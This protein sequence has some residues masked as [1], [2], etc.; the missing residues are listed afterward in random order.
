[1]R[2]MAP[3]TTPGNSS[4]SWGKPYFQAWGGLPSAPPP[5]PPTGGRRRRQFVEMV[6][7]DVG[8]KVARRDVGV[9]ET[10]QDQGNGGGAGGAGVGGRVARPSPRGPAGRRPP[11]AAIR[12]PGSGLPAATASAPTMASKRAARPRAS[13]RAT[14]RSVRLLV[15][16]A[17]RARR[18]QGVQR[19]RHAG[20]GAAVIGDVGP[21]V[22][23]EALEEFVQARLGKRLA[24]G[25]E[26]SRD[27]RPAP[28]ADHRPRRLHGQ[29]GYAFGAKHHVQSVHQVRRGV[30]QG[31]VEVQGD[32]G[33]GEVCEVG[34]Q[35]GLRLETRRRFG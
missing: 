6:D 21:I 7:Q 25:G 17:R 15:Q 8:P 35:M 23:D 11:M 31:A 5:P 14:D 32:G 1:M 19:R 26:P 27:Q 9:A 28:R 24:R 12:W 13:S 2:L 10:D 3:T 16:T 20:K 34:G 4:P 29:G 22:G 33:A 30:D 18:R